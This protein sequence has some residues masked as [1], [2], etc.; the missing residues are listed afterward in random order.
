MPDS[1]PSL[2]EGLLLHQNQPNGKLYLMLVLI[3]RK[4]GKV[5]LAAAR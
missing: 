2:N 1:H 5:H 4:C 3:Q